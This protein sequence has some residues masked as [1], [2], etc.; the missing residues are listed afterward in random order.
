MVLYKD[1]TTYTNIDTCIAAVKLMYIP[2]E[3]RE[4]QDMVE[5]T[6]LRL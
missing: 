4:Y 5:P 6:S 3:V 1:L 2:C